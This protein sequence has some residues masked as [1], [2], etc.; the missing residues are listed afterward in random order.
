MRLNNRC[1]SIHAIPQICI[2]AGD[3]YPFESCSVSKHWR[4]LSGSSEGKNQIWIRQVRSSWLRSGPRLCDRLHHKCDPVSAQIEK[5]IIHREEHIS[6]Q[7][8][9]YTRFQPVCHWSS[10]D[11]TIRSF[12]WSR[13]RCTTAWPLSFARR[14]PFYTDWSGLFVLPSF[15]QMSKLPYHRPLFT[16]NTRK[17]L[18]GFIGTTYLALTM[19]LDLYRIMR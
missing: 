13:S 19:K 18:K 5:R 16:L 8:L 9:W 14:I 17:Y 15:L 6:L 12:H 1:E 4:L 7:H 2:P 11:S 3:I 10:C